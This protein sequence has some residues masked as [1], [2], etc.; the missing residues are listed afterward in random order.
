MHCPKCLQYMIVLCVLVCHACGCSRINK[1]RECQ[2]PKNIA[3]YIAANYPNMRTRTI[4]DLSKDDKMFWSKF[5][6]SECPGMVKGY[7]QNDKVIDIAVLIVPREK[8][9]KGFKVIVFTIGEGG[10]TVTTVLDADQ[11]SSLGQVIH[12]TKPGTYTDAE[13]KQID[14]QR[15]GI[16]IE[17]IESAATIYYWNGREY[18]SVDSND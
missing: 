13:G 12:K 17:K 5:S 11:S 2:L 9:Q 7:F 10:Y 16:V 8:Q 1:S 14:I 18:M 4:D 6:N 3:D 15:D